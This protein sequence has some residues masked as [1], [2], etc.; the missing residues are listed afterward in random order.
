MHY[1]YYT[2]AFQLFPLYNNTTN[3]CLVFLSNTVWGNQNVWQSQIEIEYY[4]V[5]Y[6]DTSPYA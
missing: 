4:F 6:F 2:S 5:A 3:S 1:T